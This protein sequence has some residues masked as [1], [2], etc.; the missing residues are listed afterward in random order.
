MGDYGGNIGM[1]DK[2]M[3]AP[4][5]GLGYY[6]GGYRGYSSIWRVLGFRV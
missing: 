1:M 6:I 4:I 5:M 3:E 2:K